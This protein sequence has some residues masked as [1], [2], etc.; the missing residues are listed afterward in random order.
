MV[1]VPSVLTPVE[2]VTLGTGGIG[3]EVTGLLVLTGGLTGSGKVVTGGLV[4]CTVF[5][6]VLLA[7]IFWTMLFPINGAHSDQ[8]LPMQLLVF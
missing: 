5:G 6:E 8:N 4:F 7:A 3:V 1:K 2:A